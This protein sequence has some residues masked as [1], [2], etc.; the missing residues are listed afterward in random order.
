MCLIIQQLL[1][2]IIWNVI[3]SWTCL[4]LSNY[5]S[6]TLK[7]TM[8]FNKGQGLQITVARLLPVTEKPLLET[9]WSPIVFVHSQVRRDQNY[10]ATPPEGTLMMTRRIL[11]FRGHYLGTAFALFKTFDVAFHSEN[12]PSLKLQ[13]V[14]GHTTLNV[15]NLI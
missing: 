10:S 3:S 5:S 9:E 8:N 13:K 14:Y 6:L 11:L 1:K 2:V 15:P 7:A 4:D 12:F